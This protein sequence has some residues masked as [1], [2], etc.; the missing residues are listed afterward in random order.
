MSWGCCQERV[1]KGHHSITNLLT[2]QSQLPSGG[3]SSPSQNPATTPTPTGFETPRSQ[4]PLVSDKFIRLG[5]KATLRL[6]P[7]MLPTPPLTPSPPPPDPIRLIKTN[8]DSNDDL[9]HSGY[10]SH[11]SDNT[12][13]SSDQKKRFQFTR[14]Q[15]E[16][17]MEAI[18]PESLDDFEA[19]VF[20][21]FFYP[22]CIRLSE[23]SYR[24]SFKMGPMWRRPIFVFQELFLRS[25]CDIKHDID[26]L[27][28]TILSQVIRINDKQDGLLALIVPTMPEK[29]RSSLF[30]NL[31]TIF[32]GYMKKINTASRRNNS[33][34]TTNHFTALNLSIY[35]RYSNR[36]CG[37]NV[38]VVF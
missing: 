22:L 2:I 10:L 37:F 1:I 19:K 17:A 3:L 30:P 5:P 33:P 32:P 16:L 34:G 26:L 8:F 7:A 27:S 9:N 38:L 29:I 11:V 13:D 35:N 15:R 23:I 18:I 24:I 20:F 6:T 28:N 12:S 4:T 21:F 14:R 36:V 25:E 31:D